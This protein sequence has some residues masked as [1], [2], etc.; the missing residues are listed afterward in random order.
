MTDTDSSAP[1]TVR[2]AWVTWAVVVTVVLSILGVFVV[3]WFVQG[4][5]REVASD[6][7][8]VGFNNRLAAIALIVGSTVLALIALLSQAGRRSTAGR[9]EPVVVLE[10]C[11]PG[12]RVSLVVLGVVS[13]ALLLMLTVMASVY[14]GVLFGDAGYF[15]D[16][17]MYLVNGQRFA[18]GF[19]F[20]YGPLLLFPTYW[21][22]MVL[23]HVGIGLYGT[24]YIFTAVYQ[25]AGLL[26]VAYLLNRL[27]MPRVWRNVTLAVVGGFML[28]FVGLG[29]NYTPV[30]FLA[31]FVLLLW[32][33]RSSEKH[34]LPATALAPV[35]GVIVSFAVSAEMGFVA[36]VGMVTAF[37]IQAL[38]GRLT[39]WV[40]V[41]SA[42]AGGV[43]GALAYT[44]G[45]ASMFGAFSAGA[46]YFPVLPGQPA[47]AYVVTMLL[48]GWGVG[49]TTNR[50]DWSA[51][52]PQ[53]GWFA[54]C[55]V[56]SAAAMGR[57]DFVHIFWNGAAAILLASALL[58]RTGQR[59][60]AAYPLAIGVIF[61][62]SGIGYAWVGLGPGIV[63]SAARSGALTQ[64]R[65]AAIAAFF[66]RPESMGRATWQAA[67]RRDPLPEDVKLLL[68]SHAALPLSALG[69]DLGM[70]LAKSKWLA[71]SYS[72]PWSLYSRAQID[73]ELADMARAKFLLLPT[74]EYAEYLR[75]YAAAKDDMQN[76]MWVG[77]LE[78]P[79]GS[80]AAM[81]GFAFSA[82]PAHPT[83]DTWA[84]FGKEFTENWVGYKISGDYM[85]LAR[86]HK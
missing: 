8:A 79:P 27:R 54:A 60:A 34:G 85:I 49:A 5:I 52:A 39:D 41:A 37:G 29:H 43:A 63:T 19:E 35:A 55:L 73:R 31:P 53:M 28:T 2:P 13:F 17:L 40:G 69:G 61:I 1:A 51:A 57:S 22:Y 33:L 68:R 72:P 11:E 25:V 47:F 76:G 14:R 81:T 21:L 48:V 44:A 30:R 42:L 36:C 6:S 50:R 46:V 38:A 66:G 86:R 80:Y 56:L 23:R 82:Q 12:E 24:Y 70:A 65:S 4:T 59:F 9:A 77:P 78:R 3:P 67:Q 64:E 16:R 45:G 83:L 15:I 18:V 58:W 32:A 20:A 74:S 62:V 7:Q 84:I 75:R 71:K 10:R 26:M